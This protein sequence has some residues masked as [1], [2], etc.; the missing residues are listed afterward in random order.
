MEIAFAVCTLG[1]MLGC[2]LCGI[3]VIWAMLSN[4]LWHNYGDTIMGFGLVITLGNCV[5]MLAIFLG[6]SATCMVHLT[7]CTL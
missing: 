4:K 6:W 2:I 5:A 1:I 7:S 3:G